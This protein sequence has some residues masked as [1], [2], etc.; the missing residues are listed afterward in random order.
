[1]ELDDDINIWMAVADEN[2]E[3]VKDFINTL[4]YSVNCADDFGY[5][6]LHAA[7]SYGH[8]NIISFLIHEVGADIHVKDNDGDEPIHYCEEPEVYEYLIECGFDPLV[9]NNEGDNLFQKC[10][11]DEN[12][13]MV[14][15]LISKG[16]GQA[17]DTLPRFQFVEE[18]EYDESE[19]H[20]TSDWEND[21]D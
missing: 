5:T 11:D 15:F 20:N 10:I 16:I 2:L 19:G 12:E 13:V 21:G 9:K 1:M 18:N 6:P 8:I 3:K 17:S 7:V 14:N 4:K